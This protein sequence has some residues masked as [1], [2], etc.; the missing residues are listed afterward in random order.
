MVRAIDIITT[1]APIKDIR[2]VINGG[3]SNGHG[4]NHNDEED[5]SNGNGHA[6]TEEET[7]HRLLAE[8][9]TAGYDRG[10]NEASK[11][12]ETR[13]HNMRMELD[14]TRRNGV[15]NLLAN[16]E[17]TVQEQVTRKLKEL[18]T[19][20]IALSTEAAIRLVNGAPI[21]TQMLE[22]GVREALLN[23]EQQSGIVIY[24]NPEDIALLR[25]DHSA[26]LADSPHSRKIQFVADTKI[27]RGGCLVETE[28]GVIDGQRETRMELLKQTLIR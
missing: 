16:L 2:I 19:Q 10:R 26:M 18:E 17:Q 28:S 15:T 21:S 27:S 25:D 22:A 13:L 3:A 24:M 7:G 11:E 12:Y 1:P 23:A 4:H 6:E 5:S 9:E 20:L 8:R 14:N